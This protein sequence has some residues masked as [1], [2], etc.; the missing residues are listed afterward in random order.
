MAKKAPTTDHTFGLDEP[1]VEKARETLHEFFDKK[2]QR[3]SSDIATARIASS[4]L[5][6]HAR[7]RQAAGAAEA[8][9]FM[10]A[11]ELSTDKAQLE[12]F[13]TAAMPAAPILKALPARKSES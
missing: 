9:Q 8:L 13:L 1:L 7:E 11:R 2:D 12:A 4:L 5:S 3:T 10:I 6:T